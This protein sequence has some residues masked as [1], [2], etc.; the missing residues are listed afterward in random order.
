MSPEGADNRLYAQLVLVGVA[1]RDLD[2]R[3]ARHALDVAVAT[4]EPRPDAASYLAAANY[5][6]D[7]GRLD[8]QPGDLAQL[9]R[10][11]GSW[12]LARAESTCRQG[13]SPGAAVMAN[14]NQVCDPALSKPPAADQ[15]L[16]DEIEGR[17][18]VESDRTAG[19]ALLE[20]AIVVAEGLRDDVT[21]RRART[22]AY[23]MLVFDAARHGDYARVMSLVAAELG[24]ARPGPCTVAMVAEDERAAVVVRGSDGHDRATYDTA[25]RSRD[26]ALTVSPDLA[27]SLEGCAHV[28]VMAQA[29]LQGQPRILPAT[30][31]WSYLTGAGDV[32]S[33]QAKAPTD[34]RTLIVTNV[35]PPSSL[36]LPELSQQ[37][38]DRTPSTLTLSGPD[39]TP[40][41]VVAALP[42]ATEIQF[43]T[44]ALVDAGISDASYLVLSPGV[45]G[46]HALTAE[47]IRR[48]RLRGHPIV[49]LAACNSAQGAKYQHAPWSLPE[50]FLAAGARVVFA[51]GT[52]VPDLEAGPFFTRVL[53]RIRAGAN[54]A[55]A[56]RDERLAATAS[57]SAS[58]TADVMLFE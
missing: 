35:T 24:L 3:A 45:D 13:A 17:L 48:T 14:R 41:N 22:G 33:P 30:L 53:V 47:V 55:R 52:A 25:R 29:M 37:V 20:K 49:V 4:G 2:G 50:A 58:W 5:L 6:A 15:A 38:P 8:H 12:L 28:R 11:L 18:L 46:N 19:V 31:P 32:A 43:Q 44:H 51:T 56:L 1:I 34:V 7:I 40:A 36:Q 27:H 23:S 39:A 57:D 54:P 42:A 26:G 10:W 16:A 9:Q 21:A